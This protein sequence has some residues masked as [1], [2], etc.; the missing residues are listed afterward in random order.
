MK[1]Q[2]EHSCGSMK[3]SA[4]P[5]TRTQRPWVP[6]AVPFGVFIALTGLAGLFP[7]GAPLIYLIKTLCVGALLWAWRD[8]YRSDLAPKVTLLG[9]FSAAVAGLLILPIWL[10]PDTVLP[11]FGTA[12]GFDPHGFGGPP[13]LVFAWIA[14][15]LMGAAVVV[16]VMEELFWRSFLL[17]YLIHA[18]FQKVALGT[19]TWVSFTVGVVLFGLEHHRWIQGI[20][21]GTVYAALVYHQKSL[22]GAILA[23]G[24]TNLSLGVYVIATQRWEFW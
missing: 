19:F 4:K 24:V 8:H 14:V 2:P 10:L 7:G 20:I 1:S 17:R 12:T 3:A 13:A 15:R 18:D 5:R 22:R 9:Y 23:H 21:A 11:Q 16:P 6:Y